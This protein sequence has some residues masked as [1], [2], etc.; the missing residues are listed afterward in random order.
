M[1]ER[2]TVA[3]LTDE[4]IN[5][6]SFHWLCHVRRVTDG[7]KDNSNFRRSGVDGQRSFNNCALKAC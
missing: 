2:F 1:H 4:T 7:N 3:V 5:P 6:S